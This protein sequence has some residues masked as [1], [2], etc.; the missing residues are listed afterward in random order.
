MKFK[1][2]MVKFYLRSVAWFTKAAR[3]ALR[4]MNSKWFKVAVGVYLASII[5]ISTPNESA[6]VCR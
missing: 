3:F 6:K 5:V 1:N 4:I 2:L